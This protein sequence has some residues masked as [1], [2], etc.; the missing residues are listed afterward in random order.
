MK[1]VVEINFPVVSN[2]NNKHVEKATFP[3]KFMV[4][5][6][7]SLYKKSNNVLFESYR[8]V[9]LFSSV[10]ESYLLSVSVKSI[11]VL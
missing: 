2:I 1:C 4:T 3:E 9:A 5:L 11:Y 10:Q 8:S 6:M 7:K